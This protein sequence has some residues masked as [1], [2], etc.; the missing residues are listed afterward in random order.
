MQ[1]PKVGQRVRLREDPDNSQ[2]IR[3]YVNR[4][5]IIVRLCLPDGK[6]VD[7][8][9]R[10]G[11]VLTVYYWMLVEVSNGFIKAL[12]KWKEYEAEV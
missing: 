2:S 7:V 12:R 1:K 9:F 3:P 4:L 8:K 6:L 5:G 11:K 10:D